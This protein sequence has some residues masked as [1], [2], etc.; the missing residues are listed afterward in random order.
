MAGISMDE[1]NSPPPTLRTRRSILAGVVLGLPVAGALGISLALAHDDDKDEDNSGSGNA[2]DK[3][4]DDHDDHAGDDNACE[5]GDDDADCT[6]PPNEVHIV[7]DDD[8]GFSPGSIEVAVGTTITFVNDDDDPHTATGGDWDTGIIQPGASAEITFD[9]V[10]EFAYACQIHPV[11]TGTVVVTGAGTPV[12]S[13]VASPAPAV[14]GEVRIFNFAYE[15]ASITVPTG[16][17]VTWQNDD[18]VPH[19]ATGRGGSFD[20]G[21][22]DGGGTGTFTFDTAGTYEYGCAFHAGMSGTVVV[23]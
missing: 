15:P 12:A 3:F 19:T 16:T 23:T 17:T 22:I 6:W 2:D 8:H 10:G 11:M 21:T 1:N 4:K 13:P 5:P 18:Q 9:E 14:A 7:D 20:T